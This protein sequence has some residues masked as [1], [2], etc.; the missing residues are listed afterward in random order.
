MSV[1]ALGMCSARGV[2]VT[3]GAV[4]RATADRYFN[5][6]PSLPVQHA[7]ELA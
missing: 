1:F 3:C 5:R 2:V 4:R 7:S 6:V